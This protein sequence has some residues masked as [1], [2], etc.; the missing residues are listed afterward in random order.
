MVAAVMIYIFYGIPDIENTIL[1]PERTKLIRY[2]ACSL[3]I[4]TK[5]CNSQVVKDICLE[6]YTDTL[7]CDVEC[8]SICQSWPQGPNEACGR[9]YYIEL[10][11]EGKGPLGGVPLKGIYRVWWDG[12]NC[13]ECDDASDLINF[14]KF[15]YVPSCRGGPVIHIPS[16][17]MNIIGFPLSIT[18]LFTGISSGGGYPNF[19]K[20]SD[21]VDKTSLFGGIFD[22]SRDEIGQGAI[23]LDQGMTRE[24]FG[25]FKQ[26]PYESTFAAN[27]CGETWKSL[28]GLKSKDMGYYQC[29]FQGNLYLWATSISDTEPRADVNINASP[30]EPSTFLVTVDPF[31]PFDRISGNTITVKPGEMAKYTVEIEN[32][33]GTGSDFGLGFGLLDELDQYDICE[34]ILDNNPVS[35]VWILNGEK[36][37]VEL[38]CEVPDPPPGSILG[39]SNR[40]EVK[41]STSAYGS[42]L[43]EAFLEVIDMKLDVWEKGG[44]NR[45]DFSAKVSLN[46]WV[47]YVVEVTSDFTTSED[48]D[49]T[50]NLPGGSP[51]TCTFDDDPLTVNPGPPGQTTMRC[52]SSQ[53]D[54]FVFRVFATHDETGI[55]RNHP[56][57]LKVVACLG[58]I[59]LSIDKSEVAFGG[60]FNVEASGLQDCNGKR[61][62]FRIDGLTASAKEIGQC[63]ITSGTG[64]PK[65]I[66]VDD[67]DLFLLGDHTVY[68]LID[69]TGD[70]DYNDMGESDW[71]KLTIYG[72]T[73]DHIEVLRES[74]TPTSSSWTGSDEKNYIDPSWYSPDVTWIG[75]AKLKNG[76]C[77]GITWGAY[78]K[79]HVRFKN[80]DTGQETDEIKTSTN[81][82]EYLLW[83]LEDATHTIS[84]PGLWELEVYS[85]NGCSAVWPGGWSPEPIIYEAAIMPV[86]TISVGTIKSADHIEVLRE[87]EDTWLY[88]E[89]WMTIDWQRNYIN[90]TWY[91]S[92]SYKCYARANAAPCCGPLGCGIHK[93]YGGATLEIRF[94]NIDT[95]ETTIV[96]KIQSSPSPESIEW[97]CGELTTTGYWV[98]EIRSDRSTGSCGSPN[99]WGA[100]DIY[101]ATMIPQVSYNR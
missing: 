5:G 101:E 84:D 27:V 91:G 19:P 98:A 54:D 31:Y 86:Q 93:W 30:P 69:L 97:D 59:K 85:E 58:E 11:L 74:W 66:E 81:V 60:S 34:F 96:K 12:L 78:R 38:W 45:D 35:S 10:F 1:S 23:L 77:N 33:L 68:A 95:D 62:R 71:K 41:V 47:E 50:T 39:K 76:Y 26:S 73:A 46:N 90:Q 9:N 22:N 37:I 17:L 2:Y 92:T 52:K 83:N 70:G 42:Q 61:V 14:M 55:Q 21:L 57:I 48:F 28:F 87:K 75:Y 6:N 99:Y 65:T 18:G 7:T 100:A 25:C 64:C 94:K 80:I 15:G 53:L 49:L 20:P 29:D 40:I 79:L 32:R 4:C 63:D 67:I 8:K 3:A 44:V 56:V 36:K 13:G 89:E 16:S 24:A 51:V 82:D 72:F 43:S 88:D